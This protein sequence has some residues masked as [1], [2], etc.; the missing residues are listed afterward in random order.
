MTGL[1]SLLKR[2][3]IFALLV[4]V[5]SRG[6]AISANIHSIIQYENLANAVALGDPTP[7]ELEYFEIPLR[8]LET[9]ASSALNSATKNSLIFYKENEAYVKWIIHPLDKKWAPILEKWLL[10]QGLSTKRHK[11]KSAY[12][13]ASRSFIIDDSNN[14]TEFSIKVS[15][16]QSNGIWHDKKETWKSALQTR[17]MSDYLDGRM[18]DIAKPT[19]FVILPEPLA[20]GI[21]SIDQGMILRSYEPLIST[22]FSY[23]P[24]FSILHESVGA[25][26]ALKNGSKDP[27]DFWNKH[28]NQALARALAELF[29]YAG[30]SLSSTHSQNFLLELDKDQKPTG[31]IVIRDIGDVILQKEYFEIVGR[32]DILRIWEPESITQGHTIIGYGLLH[33]GKAPGW[34]DTNLLSSASR[35]GSYNKWARDFYAAFENHVKA[36]SPIVLDANQEIPLRK[37]NFF[38]QDYDITNIHQSQSQGF[39]QS[40]V[41]S[42]VN[43]CRKI[44]N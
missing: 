23:V 10:D 1:Q 11:M 14:S 2:H 33:G 28:Y 19:K 5:G 6:F 37:G 39:I 25:E 38:M 32:P 8:F 3:I 40:L 15:T 31:R 29:V 7:I 43:L 24:G 36:I 44:Y 26:I 16:D 20:F 42:K 13:T 12:R 35:Q 27:A 18:Q 21:S 4:L 41:R 9:T 30:V 17:T 22:D 34:I